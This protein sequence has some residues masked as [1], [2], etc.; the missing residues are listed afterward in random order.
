MGNP[1]PCGRMEVTSSKGFAELGKEEGGAGGRWLLV[2]WETFY[3]EGVLLAVGGPGVQGQARE[4]ATERPISLQQGDVFTELRTD[5]TGCLTTQQAPVAV[6]VQRSQTL[7][8]RL[9]GRRRCL[10]TSAR[11]VTG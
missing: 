9:L 2:W 5:A 4:G 11:R 8:G 7:A 1:V 6:S 10:K 3:G